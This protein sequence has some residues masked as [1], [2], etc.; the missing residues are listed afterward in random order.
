M[1]VC[2]REQGATAG[3]AGI[4]PTERRQ[5]FFRTSGLAVELEITDRSDT[6][7]VTGQLI[8]RQAAVVD[9]RHPGGTITVAADAAGRFSAASVPAGPASLRCHLGTGH[10]HT[11]V[12]TGWLTV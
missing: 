10:G 5:L 2:G 11:C 3:K 1:S 8:P 4:S 6:R 9:I 12:I 7:Q